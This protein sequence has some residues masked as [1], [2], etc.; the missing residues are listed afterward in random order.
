MINLHERMLPTSAGVEP[1]TWSPVG[2][3]IQLSH[4]GRVERCQFTLPHFYWAGLV[5][6]AVNQYCAHSLARNN[7]PSWFS[8]RERMIIENISW[9]ISTK[10]CC[11]PSGNLTNSQPPE[12]QSDEKDREDWSVCTDTQAGLSICWVHMQC[13]RKYCALGSYCFIIQYF[14]LKFNLNFNLHYRTL[15]S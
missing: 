6:S 1:A 3:R 4:R 8:G 11:R 13:L 10:E 14:S 7:C 15:V 9:S 12:H 2:R 5:L